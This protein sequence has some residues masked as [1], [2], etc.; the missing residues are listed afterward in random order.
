MCWRVIDG[1]PLCPGKR[2]NSPWLVISIPILLI[3]E[4]PEDSQTKSLSKFKDLPPWDFPPTLTP[5]MITKTEA[6]RKG[7]T[8]DLIGLAFFSKVSQHFIARYVDKDSSQIYTY[9]GMKDK[10]NAI[11]D[12]EPDT[13]LAT[14]IQVANRIQATSNI[15]PTYVPSLAIYHLRGGAEAQKAFY[16]SQTKVCEKMYKLRFSTD[17]PSTLPDVTYCGQECPIVAD[18]GPHQKKKE[19]KE[20]LSKMQPDPSLESNK[21]PTLPLP[22]AVAGSSKTTPPILVSDQPES[23]EE[24]TPAI[25]LPVHAK[26][27]LKINTETKITHSTSSSPRHGIDSPKSPPDSPFNINCRCGLNGDGNIYYNEK[28]GEAVLCAECEHW[29]HIACQRNG[30]ASKLRAKEAFFCDFCLVRAPGMGKSDKDHAAERRC[31]FNKFLFLSGC[32]GT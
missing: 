25:R 9:D 2:Q 15:P 4:T 28:E 3:I 5:S 11:P 12:S 21:S 22:L 13:E 16:Q 23:E 1:V 30:R 32:S 18:P 20:Y 26:P 29:S 24:T 19:M 17:E 10:G 14:H 27:G 6:K 31:A 7:I 8:Y